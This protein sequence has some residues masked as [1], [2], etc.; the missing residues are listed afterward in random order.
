M[1]AD[2]KSVLPDSLLRDLRGIS[3]DG[4]VL[5]DEPMARHTT[6]GIGGPADVLALPGDADSA[7]SVLAACHAA[8]VPV[9]VVGRGSNILVSDNGIRGVALCLDRISGCEAMMR[10]GGHA[11]VRAG[12]GMPLPRLASA[13]MARGLSG[14]EF[15]QGI[16]G[17]VGGAVAM[18]AGAFGGSTLGV[19][20]YAELS[21]ME[22]MPSTASADELICGDGYRNTHVAG[23]GLVVLAAAFLLEDVGDPRAVQTTMR[24]Y[25]ERRRTTQ[26]TGVRSAGSAFKRPT[27][28]YAARLIDE[29]GLKG[30]RVGGAAV[31]ERHAGFVVNLGGATSADVVAVM[32]HVRGVVFDR[33]G[34][35]LEPEVRF[36]GFDGDPLA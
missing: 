16:P 2:T 36:V 19:L 22:G 30:Y 3:G 27:G 26:P 11:I 18:N 29:A 24:E 6:F 20:S 23:R 15:A 4:G 12:A 31:S 1:A 9:T 34:V 14:L 10:S 28:D 7:M 8:D 35:A 25:A 5:I 21:D 13:C 32:R 17:N 33:F